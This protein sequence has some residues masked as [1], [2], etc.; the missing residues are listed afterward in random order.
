MNVQ[1]EL[2]IYRKVSQSAKSSKKMSRILFH[3]LVKYAGILINT[4]I[5]ALNFNKL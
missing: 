2:N 4:V 5:M 3:A 1:K